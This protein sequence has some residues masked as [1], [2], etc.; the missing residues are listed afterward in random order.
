MI[1]GALCYPDAEIV[2]Y[3]K[4]KIRFWVCLDGGRR[5]SVEEYHEI[6]DDLLKCVQDIPM[7]HVPEIDREAT[8]AASF[9]LAYVKVRFPLAA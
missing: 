3:L 5:P 2:A 1:V 6:M 8:F 9:A 7:S 4:G